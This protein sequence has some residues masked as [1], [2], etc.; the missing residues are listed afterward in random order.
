MS[1]VSPMNEPGI[2]TRRA[3]GATPAQKTEGKTVSNWGGAKQGIE[4]GQVD[5][6]GGQGLPGLGIVSGKKNKDRF[7]SVILVI[8]V[9]TEVL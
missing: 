1:R 3:Y 8:L 4:R 5:P 6:G 9:F 2:G 7:D